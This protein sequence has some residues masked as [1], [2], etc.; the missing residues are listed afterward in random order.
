MRPTKSRSPRI[1]EALEGPIALTQCAQTG[2]QASCELESTCPTRATWDPVTR[3][4]QAALSGLT[5]A[6]LAVRAGAAAEPALVTLG[7]RLGA[8]LS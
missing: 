5:L 4:V 3:A 1:V 7:S 6:A 2:P 8:R